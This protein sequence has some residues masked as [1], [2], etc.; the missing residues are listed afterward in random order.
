MK[1]QFARMIDDLTVKSLSD[2][3]MLIE[4]KYTKN[5][6]DSD[7][8]ATPGVFSRMAIAEDMQTDLHN[9][10]SRAKKVVAT[11]KV[12]AGQPTCP[13]CGGKMHEGGIAI[14]STYTG[15]PDFISGEAITMHKGGPGRVVTCSKCV[16]C[17]HSEAQDG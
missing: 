17:G 4:V 6:I 8:P 12:V 5:E 11:K 13:K 9:N 15:S 3:N 7:M 14:E 10:L 16:D 1:R 2:G